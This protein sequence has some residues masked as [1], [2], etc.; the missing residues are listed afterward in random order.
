MT[1]YWVFFSL[2]ANCLRTPCEVMAYPLWGDGVPP[3]VRVPQVEN[4]WARGFGTFSSDELRCFCQ[5]NDLFFLS[6][7]F[8]ALLPVLLEPTV[9]ARQGPVLTL[10]RVDKNT[11]LKSKV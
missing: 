2:T 10:R 9:S 11:V 1:I 8:P 3:G 6:G 7:A 4:R 5:K